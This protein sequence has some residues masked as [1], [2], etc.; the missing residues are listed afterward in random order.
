MVDVRKKLHHNIKSSTYMGLSMHS[1]CRIST[2]ILVLLVI[3]AEV[4]GLK[5]CACTPVYGVILWQ[6]N[7][8]LIEAR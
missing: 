8:E 2:V 4:A 3:I 1:I 7:L 6:E 5:S